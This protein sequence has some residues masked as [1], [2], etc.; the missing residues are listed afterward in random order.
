[1]SFL[2]KWKEQQGVFMLSL[3]LESKTY[4]GFFEGRY[5]NKRPFGKSK[6]RGNK[7]LSECALLA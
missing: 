4:R 2:S 7:I 1:M 6:G 3:N 5:Q